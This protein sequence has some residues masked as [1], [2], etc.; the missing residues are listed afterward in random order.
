MV[1]VE[2]LRAERL[3]LFNG[4]LLSLPHGKGDVIAS[5]K[6]GKFLAECKGGRGV[7]PMAC[8]IAN[9]FWSASS[10]TDGWSGGIFPSELH[11]GSTGGT[12]LRDRS[13]CFCHSRMASYEVNFRN[14]PAP[15]NPGRSVSDG[16]LAKSS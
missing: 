11:R 1:G 14:T 3:S 5:T 12:I 4:L 6:D 8:G 16:S 9:G 15:F 13:P 7:R 2:R 10:G